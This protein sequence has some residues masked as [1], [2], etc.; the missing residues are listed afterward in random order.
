MAFSLKKFRQ[1]IEGIVETRLSEYQ[2]CLDQIMKTRKPHLTNEE[3]KAAITK[4]KQESTSVN[5]A[6]ILPEVFALVYE[7]VYRALGYYP[8]PEQIITGIALS[9]GKLVEMQTGEG[10]T[11]AAV[12]PAV[13][14]ALTGKGVH[15]L[16]F[17]DYLAGRDARWMGPI[18]ELCGLTVDSI[19]EGMSPIE[20]R[21]AYNA[22]ITYM[23]AKEAGFDFLRDQ[24]VMDLKERVQRPFHFAIID[25]ADSIMIDEA[26][27]PLVIAGSTD[28]PGQKTS[29]IAET[30][31]QLQKGVDFDMDEYRRN[32]FLTEAGLDR[33]E[34]LLDCGNI[35]FEENYDLLTRMNNA[36]RAEYLLR[37]DVDY[38]VTDGTIELLDEFTGR[39][40][41][42]RHWPDGLQEAI[43]AKEGLQVKDRGR[44]LGSVTLQHFLELYPK[45]SGMTATA[46]IAAE[47]FYEFYGLPVVIIPP[48]RPCIRMDNP[49]LVFTHKEAK[50]DALVREITKVHKTGRPILVGTASVEESED[51]AETLKKA[52][53]VCDVLNAKTDELEASIIAGAGAIG[54][55][56]IS[57]NMAGRGTDIKL[58]GAEQQDRDAVALLGGLYVI[59]TSRYESR[60][61]DNQLRGRSGRQGDPGSSRFFISLEDDLIV[62]YRIDQLLPEL[63]RS[64][65]QQQPLEEPQ[66]I[67]EIERAQ[68]IIEGQHFDMRRMLRKYSAVLESERRLVQERRMEVLNEGP[69]LKSFL[70]QCP[71]KY[72][73]ITKQLGETAAIEGGRK[74]MLYHIDKAWSEHLAFA[75]HIREGI[76]LVSLTGK[77]PIEEFHYALIP[78][79]YEFWNKVKTNAQ[80]DYNSIPVTDQGFNLAEAGLKAPSSSWTYL[81]NDQLF[82]PAR[83]FMK[84]LFGKRSQSLRKS[85]FHS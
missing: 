5:P 34:K 31:K 66:V 43:E 32:I 81:V 2:K 69:Y 77:R 27:V 46:E 11:L 1:Q 21:N 70:E 67:K 64:L 29:R 61:V 72:L 56:T 82:D 71:E 35:Y 58:G 60:R 50:K 83:N 8:F 36:L 39:V 17:N 15:I 42:K 54:A 62:R 65:R 16:T 22:D 9:A 57:T 75:A 7:A 6:K 26:R 76:H 85:I 55:V 38:L 23:T 3:L 28:T 25:E 13:L 24:L 68:R 37:R 30:V 74:V 52:G 84:F 18:Y 49:D 59:G 53:I 20:R 80:K 48:H 79:F 19:Q 47:E 78:V 12:F 4:L 73:E 40:A 33:M 44:V 14:R 45:L 63:Y 51:L 41:E 10:K